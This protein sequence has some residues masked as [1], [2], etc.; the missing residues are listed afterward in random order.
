[1]G[2]RVWMELA[3][4]LLAWGTVAVFLV[5]HLIV[6]RRKLELEAEEKQLELAARERQR[7]NAAWQAEYDQARERLA[8]EERERR[9]LE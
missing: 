5:R 3:I 9:T 2:V 1:M 4:V 6:K 8:A 7:Q